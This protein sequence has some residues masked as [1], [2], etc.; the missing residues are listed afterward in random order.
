MTVYGI[1]ARTHAAKAWMYLGKAKEAK[2]RM[3]TQF[4]YELG[5]DDIIRHCVKL[6]RMEMGTSVMYRQIDGRL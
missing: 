5:E 2:Y 4:R 1:K 6:A 3:I